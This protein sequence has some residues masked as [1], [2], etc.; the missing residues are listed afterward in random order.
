MA[1]NKNPKLCPKPAYCR[2]ATRCSKVDERIRKQLRRQHQVLQR[3]SYIKNNAPMFEE[4][5]YGWKYGPVL[6][7]IRSAYMEKIDFSK[8]NVKL[9]PEN[10]TLVMD[11]LH[12]YGMLKSWKL[13]ALTHREKSWLYSRKG[14]DNGE[15][16]DVMI[17]K[18][19][20]LLD[21]QNEKLN[22]EMEV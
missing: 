1:D 15:N 7:S 20:I 3:E 10:E 2:F 5:F 21:A 22:R 8:Q 13:S 17:L 6:K 16:G 12:K 9:C 19:H 4:D 18:E 14:L 11:V